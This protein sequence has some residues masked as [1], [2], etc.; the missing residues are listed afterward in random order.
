MINTIDPFSKHGPAFHF[1]YLCRMKPDEVFDIYRLP[2]GMR[3]IHRRIKAAVAHAGIII[4]A[5]CRH[6]RKEEHG[7]AH[8]IEHCLF[9]GTETKTAFQVFS[10]LEDVGGELNA[11][12]AREETFIYA[13]FL[14]TYYDR[15][16][17]IFE[18]I[19]LHSIFPEKELKKEKQ[20]ILEE[21]NSYKDN[22]YEM[23]YDDFDERIFRHHPLGR[24]ILGTEKAL[25]TFNRE[26]I[27][28]FMSRCYQPENMVFCS[29]GDIAGQ[30]LY[31]KILACFTQK[32]L[33]S[34]VH[35]SEI[36][37]VDLFPVE[38]YQAFTKKIK[39]R[40]FQTHC[41]VGNI[42]YNHSDPGRLPFALLVNLLGGPAMSSRLNMSIRERHGYAYQVE[43]M[44]SPF[45][46]T[47][48][49]T[50]YLGTDQN[51]L[52]RSLELLHK[53]FNKVCSKKLSAL[54]LNNAKQQYIGQ[55]AINLEINLNQMLSMGKS[56]L[57]YDKVDTFKEIV[58]KVEKIS[59]LDLMGVANEVLSPHRL[60]MLAYQ[61]GE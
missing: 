34:V 22:P 16:L 26:K 10:H 33:R 42:A 45:E 40:I 59:A 17:D 44:Y 38:S 3:I 56:Y 36:S 51:K 28:E 37:S 8:F 57:V 12:T 47:G 48:I 31:K 30:Q 24:N 50:T 39:K 29:V 58:R 61:S 55:V 14:P 53:E 52:E 1:L 13:S 43:S 23:I 21:I 9:K 54:Q 11:Y 49:F 60:S 19:L 35:N 46:E 27:D 2:N 7:L 32:S 25:A 20:V 15:A 41:V 18:D 6:E 4:E 5:G